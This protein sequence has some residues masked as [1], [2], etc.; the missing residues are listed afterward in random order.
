MWTH[1]AP[2]TRYSLDPRVYCLGL[3]HRGHDALQPEQYGGDPATQARNLAA[4]LKEAVKALQLDV[5]TAL[6]AARRPG[7]STSYS[8][9]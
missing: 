6:A 4:A 3:V 2:G 5:A 7:T 1:Q 8:Q 9:A